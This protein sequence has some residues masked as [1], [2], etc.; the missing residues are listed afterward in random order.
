MQGKLS[1]YS[2]IMR[3]SFVYSITQILIVSLEVII[4]RERWKKPFLSRDLWQHNLGNLCRCEISISW[5]WWHFDDCNVTAIA[6]RD[7]DRCV[8]FHLSEEEPPA[9]PEMKPPVIIRRIR[10]IISIAHEIFFATS[11]FFF[12][13]R[14]LCVT[15][16][17]QEIVINRDIAI[18]CFLE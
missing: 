16:E 7:C 3:R 11:L 5:K 14:E 12:A 4:A 6:N 10:G 18:N 9:S 13:R 8:T 15:R 2:E 1:P 17:C